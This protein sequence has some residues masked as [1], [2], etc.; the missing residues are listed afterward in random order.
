MKASVAGRLRNTNLP[1]SNA[2]LP[3]FEAVMNAFQAIEEAEPALHRISIYADRLRLLEEEKLGPI[4]GFN[5]TDTGIGFTDVNYDSFQTVD[6]PYKAGRG[7]KGLG[8]FLWLKAFSRVEIESHY[9]LP[10]EAGLMC[11]KFSFVST[12]E[13]VSC[14]P[15][16]S[17]RT[18]PATTVQLINLRTPYD[19]QCPK[20]LDAIAR[21]FIGHFLPLFLDPNGP[22]LALSDEFEKIDLRKFFRENF[23]SAASKR[24]FSVQGEKFSLIGFHLTGVLAEQHSITY[25]AHYRE[26]ISERL[27]KFLPNLKMKL[28]DSNGDAFCYL[29]L[30]QSDYLDNKVNNERT[31]FSIPREAMRGEK[32][33]A[34]DGDNDISDLLSD[35]ISLRLIRD[36]ALKIV[37]DE[38]KPFIEEINSQKEA[39][40]LNFIDEDGP[41]YRFLMRY[42][43]EFIDQIPPNP[44]KSELDTALHRQLYH[45]QVALKQ[46]GARILSEAEHFDNPSDYYVRFNSFMER[47]NELGKT[48]LA[49]YVVHRRVILD[50][51]EKALV[52]DPETGKYSLER[53]VHSLVFPMR[54]TSGDVPFEQQNLWI[55]DERLTFHSFLTSDQPLADNPLLMTESES[56]PDILI[57]NRALAFSEDGQP[58]T[59]MVIIEFK[60]PDRDNYRDEDPVTQVYRLVREIREGHKKDFQGREVRPLT[61]DIPAYCYIICDLTK[62]LEIRLQNMGATP[63]P[64]NLGYYGFNPTLSAYYE[65]ISYQKL[66]ADAKKRNRIL[67]D[68]LNIP[69]SR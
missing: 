8:R 3:L 52:Q 39:A 17:S 32:V 49:Q 31:D 65:V 20:Q 7:G 25:A 33:D 11:R 64:D 62:P 26:V 40:V 4:T 10:A 45:R 51:F 37:A 42:K 23:H 22:E 46:E 27:A 1:K 43:D 6:S 54:T 59:S 21:Q 5:I 66:L 56:R 55:I 30:I 12:D 24:E 14:V 9:R 48:A 36:E 15:T 29:A 69:V 53:T 34:D 63:T 47:Y 2:L 60:R 19:D 28:H 16:S 13:E 50:L 41:Q 58:L 61:K 38:L 18:A 35:E 68:K 44:T 57:F 67:F